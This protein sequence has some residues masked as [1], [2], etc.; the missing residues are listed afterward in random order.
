MSK[1]MNNMSKLMNEDGR[2]GPSGF[3]PHVAVSEAKSGVS[4]LRLSRRQ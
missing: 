1:L 4:I 3:E 2:L